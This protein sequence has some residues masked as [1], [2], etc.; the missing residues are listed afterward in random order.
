MPG[1]YALRDFRPPTQQ[2]P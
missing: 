1:N 2:L